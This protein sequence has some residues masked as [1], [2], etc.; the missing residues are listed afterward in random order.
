MHNFDPKEL[1]SAFSSYM[2]G[3]TVVTAI[4]KSG[5]PMGFTANSFSS[6]SLTPPLLLVCP[7]NGLG[8]ALMKK[9][10]TIRTLDISS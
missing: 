4:S 2:T 1:R 7:G 8:N 3:V 6:V 5:D 10:M 9:T